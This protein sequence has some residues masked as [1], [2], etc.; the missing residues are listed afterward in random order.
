MSE[1]ERDGIRRRHFFA[2]LRKVNMKTSQEY[3][4]ALPN[5][6]WMIYL[7]NDQWSWPWSL[8]RSGHGIA[9]MVLV[10]FDGHLS[11]IMAMIMD[12]KRQELPKIT[13][14]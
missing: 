11:M 12:K 13:V 6:Y 5:D 9:A 3:K 1:K 4:T 14:F 10:M 8:S 2:C 7:V